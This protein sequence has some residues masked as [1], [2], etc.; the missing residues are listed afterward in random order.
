M[1]DKERVDP[2]VLA[3]ELYEGCDGCTETEEKMW[4]DGFVRGYYTTHNADPPSTPQAPPKITEENIGVMR[5]PKC[6]KQIFHMDTKCCY[7]GYSLRLK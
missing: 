7:C 3:D 4:K 1:K 6:K 5:C 2:R